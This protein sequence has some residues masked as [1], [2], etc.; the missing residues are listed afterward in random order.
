MKRRSFLNLVACLALFV[1]SDA[2][3]G[4]KKKPAAPPPTQSPT[5]AAVTADSV[6]VKDA[7]GSKTLTITQFTE[8]N[9]NGRKATAAELKPGM[10]V[11]VT[12]GTDPTKASR[13][14]ATG[15]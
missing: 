9:V 4:S 3:A 2:L 6:T 1:S 14:N 10:A 12:L 13:V 8:I 7:Q 11:N 5:I 15:K